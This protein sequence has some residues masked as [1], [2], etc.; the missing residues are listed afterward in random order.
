[1]KSDKRSVNQDYVVVLAA[2]QQCQRDSI[3]TRQG[4]A[5]HCRLIGQ[6][7]LTSREFILLQ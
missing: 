3:V 4:L 7:Q 5:D 1:M 2:C 6:H